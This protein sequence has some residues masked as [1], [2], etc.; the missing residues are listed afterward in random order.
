MRDARRDRDHPLDAR[1]RRARDDRLEFVGEIGKV[2]MA[3]AVDQPHRR[4][5]PRARRSAGKP[6]RAPAG[7][8][9]AQAD[10]APRCALPRARRR[11]PRNRASPAA[12]P[13]RSSSLPIAAGMHRLQQNRGDAQR[14]DRRV[15]HD[16]HARRDRSWRASRARC[17]RNSGSPWR[18]PR[19]RRR[20]RGGAAKT[21]MCSRAAPSSA[22][23][24]GEQFEIVAPS[25]RRRASPAPRRRSS[26]RSSTASAARDCRDHWRDRR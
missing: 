24:C 12:P 16:A 2:E 5:A 10:A 9:R 20:D 11:A 8:R 18:R 22:S 7:R 26:W 25:R 19:T 1:R 14:L 17:W 13:S 21:L 15:E 3:M 23:A 6:A 4:A